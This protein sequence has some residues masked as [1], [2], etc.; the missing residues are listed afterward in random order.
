MRCIVT[1][2]QMVP[3]KDLDKVIEKHD[4]F[5]ITVREHYMALARLLQHA[6]SSI[7][8]SIEAIKPVV[9]KDET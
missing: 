7:E 5:V 9:D 8:A 4:K 1:E 3:K 2:E 6:S